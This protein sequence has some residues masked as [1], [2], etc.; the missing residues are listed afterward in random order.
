MSLKVVEVDT[1]LYRLSHQE[2]ECI[3]EECFGKELAGAHDE[4]I[5]F[6]F[7]GDKDSAYEGDPGDSRSH[8]RQFQYILST[9]YRTISQ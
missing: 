1:K 6:G 7:E 2:L 8:S 5:E 4:K 3:A 9:Y